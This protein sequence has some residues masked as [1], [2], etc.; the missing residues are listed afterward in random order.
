V[1]IKKRKKEAKGIQNN[2]QTNKQTNKQAKAR[3]YDEVML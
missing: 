1:K 2:K 3:E